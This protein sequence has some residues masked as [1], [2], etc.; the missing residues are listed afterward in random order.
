MDHPRPRPAGRHPR[1]LE[2]RQD[3]AGRAA[4]IA[5]VEVV[6]VGRIEVDGLLDETQPQHARVE[7]DVRLRVGGDAGDVVNTVELHAGHLPDAS[8]VDLADLGA[9]QR[10]RDAG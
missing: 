1:E 6:D 2:E 8:A 7:V 4:L 9:I 3:R 10:R 5:V